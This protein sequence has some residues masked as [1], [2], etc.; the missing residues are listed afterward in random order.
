MNQKIREYWETQGKKVFC[1]EE[2]SPG[3]TNVPI[4][5]YHLNG[6]GPK[7]FVAAK[8]LNNELVYFNYPNWVNEEEMLKFIK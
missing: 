3:I 2:P 6:T 1:Q 7:V 5:Y 8:W 4:Y